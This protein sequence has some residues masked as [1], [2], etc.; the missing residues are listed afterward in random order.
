MNYSLFDEHVKKRGYRY[1][2]SWYPPLPKAPD[3]DYARVHGL[4][5]DCFGFL[6][7]M[8]GLMLKMCFLGHFFC[9]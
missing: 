1:A 8:V 2:T 4:L 6:S 9:L 3:S 7:E 5:S